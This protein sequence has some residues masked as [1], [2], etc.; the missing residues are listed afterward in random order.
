MLNDTV[1]QM[2]PE[3]I[4]KFDCSGRPIHRIPP[5][6]FVEFD[7]LRDL[8]MTDTHITTISS[9]TF[10]ELN[11]L[12]FLD[13]SNNPINSIESGSF[14]Q[15]TNLKRLYLDGIDIRSIPL[16]L[17]DNLP[18]LE[19]WVRPDGIKVFMSHPD[20]TTV[21][22]NPAD[23]ILY[24]F[25]LSQRNFHHPHTFKPFKYILDVVLI[26]YERYFSLY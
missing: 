22:G 25:Y 7:S 21:T 23:H 1:Q 12:Q 4:V 17:I 14:D 3:D 15:L 26:K 18:E 10:G 6:F 24:C 9:N 11:A 16:A 2:I 20:L 8:V 5:N 13:L 19:F